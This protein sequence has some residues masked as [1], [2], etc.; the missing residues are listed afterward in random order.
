MT[1][2]YLPEDDLTFVHIP[3]NAGTAIIKWFS[4]YKSFFKADPI[5][6]GH[7]ESLPMLRRTLPT[8]KT[9]A[10]VRNPWDR[11]VS[12][13]TFARD[14]QTAWCVNFRKANNLMEEFLF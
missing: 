2:F 10:V 5:F 7:H 9:F 1:A 12:F 8:N 3:K 13:Y 11:L 6:W 14:G 4:E